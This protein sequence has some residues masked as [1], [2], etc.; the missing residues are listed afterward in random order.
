MITQTLQLNTRGLA[1]SIMTQ[2]QAGRTEIGILAHAAQGKSVLRH[3]LPR[4]SFGQPTAGKTR[5]DRGGFIRVAHV[6]GTLA[7]PEFEMANAGQ[8]RTDGGILAIKATEQC[9]LLEQG[10]NLRQRFAHRNDKACVGEVMM[11][12]SESWQMAKGKRECRR[13]HQYGIHNQW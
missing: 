2:P 6:Q 5:R 11:K 1:K 13:F 9:I 7:W 10:C 12:E 8:M 3:P 4:K